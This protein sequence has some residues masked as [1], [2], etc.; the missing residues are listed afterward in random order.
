MSFSDK[1]L[2]ELKERLKKNRYSVGFKVVHDLIERLEASET[3]I[4]TIYREGTPEHDALLSLWR[5]A[6]GK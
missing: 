2:S 6:A 3:V 4:N 5:Q 1:D